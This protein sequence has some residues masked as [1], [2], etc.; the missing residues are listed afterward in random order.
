M[1]KKSQTEKKA[2]NIQSV[3]R[4]LNILEFLSKMQN[5]VG[6]AEISE[7]LG[8]NRTTIYGLLNTLITSDYVIRSEV[9]GKYTISGKMY[10]LSYTYPNRL[11]VVRFAMRYMQ[12]LANRYDITVHLG[13]LS[14]RNDVLLVNAQ[15]PSNM[16]NIRSG[17]I[18]PLHA[19]SMGKVILSYLSEEKREALLEACDMRAY[20]RYTITDRD[21]L[22]SELS[23]IREQGYG[24]DMEEYIDGTSCVAFPIFND[25]DEIVAAMSVSGTLEQIDSRLDAIITDGLRCSKQCSAEMGWG[26]YNR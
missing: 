18:F 6:V 16:Q 7:A 19:S 13:A 2:I 4:A 20:T 1:V 17:S 3:E 10:S 8:I 9:N 15:F 21:A 23:A 22:R 11:P 26:V 14:I 24:R 12:E 5:P 25:K